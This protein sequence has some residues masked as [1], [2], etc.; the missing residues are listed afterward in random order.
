MRD[1]KLKTADLKSAEVLLREL[2]IVTV[3]LAIGEVHWQNLFYTSDK[4]RDINFPA[5]HWQR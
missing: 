2:E 4:N 5:I 1:K 3:L